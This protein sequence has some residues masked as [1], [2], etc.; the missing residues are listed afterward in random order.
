MSYIWVYDTYIN[1]N[2]DITTT[3]TAKTFRMMSYINYGTNIDSNTENIYNITKYNSFVEVNNYIMKQIEDFIAV[4]HKDRN[5]GNFPNI[6][7]KTMNQRYLDI[8][9]MQVILQ[10]IMQQGLAK[11][12]GANYDSIID[13]LNN[14]NNYNRSIT[15]GLDEINGT[16]NSINY[17]MNTMLDSTIYSTVLWVILAICLVYYVFVKL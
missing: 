11:Y 16:S 15:D 3:P 7:T 2:E 8:L 9:N 10:V 17:S 14:Y 6:S 1:N 4:F 12:Y 5:V 13:V